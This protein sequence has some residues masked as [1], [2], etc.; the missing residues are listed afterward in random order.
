VAA[1]AKYTL[2]ALKM[3]DCTTYTRYIVSCRIKE[4]SW[5]CVAVMLLLSVMPFVVGAGALS[6]PDGQ[7]LGLEEAALG[8]HPV[9][10][11]SVVQCVSRPGSSLLRSLHLPDLSFHPPA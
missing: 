8:E 7:G 9:L 11:A 5:M 10:L 4:V 3:N 6:T 2:V 1:D